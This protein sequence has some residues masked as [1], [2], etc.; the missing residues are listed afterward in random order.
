[1]RVW[2]TY[3]LIG[4]VLGAANCLAESP[5]NRAL[6]TAEYRAEL[7]GLLA[8]TQEL[9]SS[10]REAP[11]ALENLPQGWPIHTE[12]GDFQVST[13]GLQRDVR[14]Y[15]K[16]KNAANAIA[17]RT[18]LESLRRE[19]DGFE[20][21]PTDASRSRATLDSILAQPEFA[22]RGPGWFQKINKKLEA[23]QKTVRDWFFKLVLSFFRF[24]QRLFGWRSLPTVGKV[25]IYGLMGAAGLALL[26]LIYRSIFQ[27][28]EFEEVVP[29]DLPVSAK[30]WF[31]WL[32][33]ARAAA[34]RGDW[35][36]AVHLGYWAGIS[37]LEREGFWK[38]DRAR[39]PREY[40]RLISTQSEQ[41]ET[42]TTLTRIFELAWYAKRDASEQT[43]SQTLEQ[44]EKLGCR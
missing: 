33:E 11:K 30:E 25:F 9:D 17:V 41:R 3:I 26:Y 13:E 37:F 44:L 23:L 7:D 35:R 34:A 32:S 19:V 42:L 12:Q 8:A 6:T 5:Q 15:D 22:G 24:I 21:S 16:D 14:R 31:I 20:K 39:T 10:G 40:L 27:N 28:P 29:K 43:F 2:R 4:L 18:R 1:M 38:P 36:D